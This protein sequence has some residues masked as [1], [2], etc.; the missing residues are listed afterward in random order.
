[1]QEGGQR[2]EHLQHS[3]WSDIREIDIKS[4]FSLKG[5]YLGPDKTGMAT[6]KL[7]RQS[8]DTQ[9]D[10]DSGFVLY[11]SS[12]FHFWNGSKIPR[13]LDLAK[14]LRG[15]SQQYKLVASTGDVLLLV[16]SID[17]LSVVRVEVVDIMCSISR[18]FFNHHAPSA[19]QCCVV[20]PA[21]I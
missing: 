13:Q 9:I 7:N 12:S 19:F 1:L 10:L 8:G 16:V 5:L 20:P 4:M 21:K 3:G 2:Y 15:L 18:T 6:E 14:R 17:D 11:T